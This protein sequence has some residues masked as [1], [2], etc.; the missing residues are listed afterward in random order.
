MSK[1]LPSCT[2]RATADG[3]A[4]ANLKVATAQAESLKI[5]NAALAQH[6]DVL[7]LRR[8]EVEKVKAERWDGKL[9]ENIYAGAPIPFLDVGKTK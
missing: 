5:Q 9:P 1:A 4:C 8:I 7:E 3:E 2:L 6:N